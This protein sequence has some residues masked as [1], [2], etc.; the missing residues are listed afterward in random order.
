MAF[1]HQSVIAVAMRGKDQRQIGDSF[2]APRDCIQQFWRPFEGVIGKDVI[3]V[4][5]EDREMN[6]HTAA[7]IVFVGFGH[8]AGRH[9][10]F[11]GK[12]AHQHLEQ[13]GIIGCAQRVGNMD[14]VD[15]KLSQTNLGCGGFDINLHRV[16]GVIEIV[17]EVIKGVE[18]AQA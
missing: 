16:A 7:G 1:G 8:K 14:Q 5:V 13:I 6:M 2:Q 18:G 15:F 12:A 3:P 17:K 9:P 4:L 11:T 10:V